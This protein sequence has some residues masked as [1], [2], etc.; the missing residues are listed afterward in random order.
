MEHRRLYVQKNMVK[1]VYLACMVVCATVTVVA[2]ILTE[3]HCV[4]AGEL[5]PERCF[6]SELRCP[7]VCV[8]RFALGSDGIGD[9]L[10]PHETI[11]TGKSMSKFI[12]TKWKVIQKRLEEN[13]K[14]MESDTHS[15]HDDMSYIVGD[16]TL[17]GTE[18]IKVFW[19]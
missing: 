17:A 1:S 3:N 9:W 11:P 18:K 4:R 12:K 13:G 5:N 16:I 10:F 19:Q 14:P 6:Y 8:V 15:V 2:P 7:P